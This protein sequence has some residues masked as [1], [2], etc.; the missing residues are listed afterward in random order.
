MAAVSVQDR[1]ADVLLSHAVAYFTAHDDAACRCGKV[2]PEDEHADH[3]AAML[4]AA[5][6]LVTPT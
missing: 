2:M 6:L 3:Q 4:A 5:G 1:A